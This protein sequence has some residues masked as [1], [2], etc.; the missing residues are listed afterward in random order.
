M[1]SFE[2]YFQY[3]NIKYT[4]FFSLKSEKW[5][6]LGCYQNRGR[7][8]NESYLNVLRLGVRARVSACQTGANDRGFAVVGVGNKR[9]WSGQ[10]LYSKYGASG[11][12]KYNRQDQ[13]AGSGFHT[14]STIVVYKKNGNGKFLTS[15]LQ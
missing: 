6:P 9:C 14:S 8:L 15:E 2:R 3:L 5:K 13:N 11:H 10:D 7:A 12:C 1:V 4:D